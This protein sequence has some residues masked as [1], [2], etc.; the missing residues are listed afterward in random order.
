[1][2][3]IPPIKS[4]NWKTLRLYVSYWRRYPFLT[5]GSLLFS[6]GL[7]LKATIMPLLVAI[8]LNQ[9]I[10]HHVV[11][12]GLLVFAGCFQFILICFNHLMDGYPISSMH[13]K[14]IANLYEDCFEYLSNQDYSF[15]ADNFSGSIVTMASRFAK[16]YTTFND[17]VFFDLLPQITIV[18][19]SVG[20]MSYYSPFI[21]ITTFV[22][23]LFSSLL[24]VK[25]ALLRL[26]LRRTA[27]AKESEQVGELADAITNILTVKTFAAEDRETTRYQKINKTRAGLFLRSWRRAVRNGFIIEVLCVTLQMIVFVGGIV[28]VHRNSIGVATFLLFQVYTFRIIENLRSSTYMVRQLEVVSGDG[29]EMAELLERSP[30]VQDKPFAEKSLIDKGAINFDDMTFRYGDAGKQAALFNHFIL[31]IKSGEKVGLVGPSGGGKTTITRLLLR[32]MDIQDGS[33]NIDGQDIRDIKQKDLRRAI[34][35]VP[36]EPLLFH[37][38]ISD[39]IR[40]GKPSATAAEVMEVAKK[41]FA[42]DFID[43]LPE[44]Y[45]TLVGERGVKLSGGQRQ[46]V[47]IARAMLANAPILVLDEAT[48][49]LDSGSEQLIQKALWQLMEDKTA[50]VI[51]H[52]LSTIQRMDRIIVLDKG[53]IIEQGSHDEL[54]KQKG[55][56]AKLWAHQSGGFI[57]V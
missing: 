30:L 1:M 26:P 29:Q 21:G 47:A 43:E 37:R 42:N 22:F 20:I 55:L 32:F 49:A 15:F 36:Q 53:R 39:N 41:S 6:L 45:D 18:L 4:P 2:P 57:E 28:A 46:R 52:R 25:F 11:N 12:V 17:T 33:I 35:Y 54:L 56:Y 7:A 27:I 13:A 24:V 23:W 8:A 16:V 34:A 31:Q 19:I 48:S 51:A 5:V 3:P 38:S 14:V 40:Y 10:N 9:L 50:V 44:G